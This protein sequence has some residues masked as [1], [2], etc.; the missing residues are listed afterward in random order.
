MRHIL[1]ILLLAIA[2]SAAGQ[3]LKAY[4]S[5]NGTQILYGKWNF[6]SGT[7]TDT[8]A[9]SA[10]L[11]VEDRI[12]IVGVGAN[13]YINQMVVSSAAAANRPIF[14]MTRARGTSL[15][16]IAAVQNSD[17]LGSFIF[18]GWTG[19]VLN[20]GTQLNAIVDGT[21]SGSTMPAAFTFT[22]LGTEKLRLSSDGRL[23]LGISALSS[24]FT[25]LHKS[26]N[27]LTLLYIS[28]DN[29]GTA[30]RTGIRIGTDATSIST[31][32][33]TIEYFG[34]NFAATGVLK[35]NSFLIEGNGANTIIGNQSATEPIQFA[36]LSTRTERMRITP[37]GSFL[38]NTTGGANIDSRRLYVNGSIGAN[39]D[40]IPIV[41]SITNEKV[42][43]QDSTTG[44][45]KRIAMFGLPPGGAPSY[46]LRKVTGSDYDVEWSA[47]DNNIVVQDSTGEYTAYLNTSNATPATA[48]TISIPA[49][50]NMM[51]QVT[52]LAIIPDGTAS[53]GCTKYRRFQ[54]AAA[55][56]LTNAT[57]H[58]IISDEYTGALTTATST[59]TNSGTD[60]IIQ[61]TGEA[62]TT[63]QWVVKYKII[64]VQ[65]SI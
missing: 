5:P 60:I 10:L 65:S 57:I 6:I 16:S 42:L 26:Q 47:I 50:T 52:I 24:T 38:V 9:T 59:I 58:D 35:P 44:R 28:N 23:G 43:I 63:L 4:G 37:A 11:N 1:I 48:A 21:V 39:K 45:I 32:Y 14:K 36:T 17:I 30:A 15:S 18:G 53:Y 7:G 61:V 8:V 3:N 41:A 40:S 22:T 13:S 54:R 31:K 34:D 62:A 46:A 20:N 51:V 55:G 49:G 12:R 27:A 2:G 33:A 19:T 56:T 25:H 64:S 29:T